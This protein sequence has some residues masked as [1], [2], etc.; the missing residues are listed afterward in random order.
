MTKLKPISMAGV[1]AA[2]QK[3]TRHRLLNEPLE[4][5]SICHDVLAI[6]PENQHA[7]ITLLLAITD[8]F[9][10]AVAS[11]FNEA[12]GLLPT[13]QDQYAQAYYE[14]IVNERWGSAQ[15]NRGIRT[16]IGWFRTAMRCY[17]RAE[18][19]SD[20]D[21]DDAILRW[22]ACVRIIDRNEF[23]DEPMTHDVDAEH[24]DDVPIR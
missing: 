5:E 23:T 4:A 13:I 24:G 2:M 18:E 7:R 14:G 12:K 10:K 15:L 19:L 11:A 21:N 9:D 16:S 3:A 17:A 6:D 20:P 1:P 8:Q 22:N